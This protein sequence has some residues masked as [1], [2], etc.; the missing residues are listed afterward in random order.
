MG[1][2]GAAAAASTYSAAAAASNQFAANP[3]MYDTCRSMYSSYASAGGPR[4][5]LPHSA[6]NLSV[7]TDSSGSSAGLTTNAIQG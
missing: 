4:A 3:S 2:F 1:S 6:I 5:F 7:K